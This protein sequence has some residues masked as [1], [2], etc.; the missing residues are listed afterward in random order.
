MQSTEERQRLLV[1]ADFGLGA[2]AVQ[3]GPVALTPAGVD[4]ML[5]ALSPTLELRVAHRLVDRRGEVFEANLR[6]ERLADFDPQALVQGLSPLADL[7]EA[8]DLLEKALADSDSDLPSIGRRLPASVRDSDLGERLHTEPSQDKPGDDRISHLLSQVQVPGEGPQALLEE[9]RSEIDRRLTRQVATLVSDSRFR[10]LETAWRSLAFLLAQGAAEAMEV[11]ILSCSKDD[12]LDTFFEKDFHREYEGRAET[13]LAAVVLGFPFDRSV[14]DLDRLGHAATM[15]ES[16]RVPFFAAMGPSYFGLKRLA[17]VPNMPDLPGK[18]RGAEYAKWN[19]FRD[20]ETSLWLSLTLNRFLLRDGLADTQDLGFQWIS[21]SAGSAADPL[22]GEG[23]WALG[24]TLAR[25]LGQ[26]GLRLPMTAIDLQSLPCREYGGRRGDPFPY[27]LEVRLL[28]D[29]A[30]EMAECG[31]VALVAEP[32]ED[33]ARFPYLPTYHRPK[34]YTTDEATRSSYQAATLPYQLFAA[35]AS[36]R[37]QE[38]VES[39]PAQHDDDSLQTHF[40]TTFQAFLGVDPQ[41]KPS[42]EEDANAP[43]EVEVADD[44]ENFQVREVT[45]RLQ[46]D[47]EICGG[48]VDLVLGLQVPR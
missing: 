29:K 9:V 1:L 46:P 18:S 48:P 3:D 35:L 17:L 33:Q 32:G 4:E 23:S 10:A 8:R 39:L 45:V 5:A 42:E 31:L 30:L 20:R 28:E 19:G 7:V 13:P 38:A 44:P 34:T 47:F 36:R 25:A 6:F 22:W 27:P 21:E 15:G 37:L 11:E 16:L 2:S 12:F 43:V 26:G 41:E 40:E 14:P 24:A